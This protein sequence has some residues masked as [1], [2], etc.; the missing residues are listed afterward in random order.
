MIAIHYQGGGNFF[1]TR[2]KQ[3]CEDNNIPFKLVS[4]YDNDILEQLNDCDALL[5]HVNNLDYRDQLLARNLINAL[6]NRDIIT[7]PNNKTLWHFDDKVA[8][9]YLFESV[10]A[11]LV[12]SYVFYNKSDALNWIKKTTFPKV[13]KLAKGGAAVNVYLIK[14]KKHAARMVKRAFNKGFPVLSMKKIF[15]ERL[16]KFTKGQEPFIGVI[17]GFI[18]LFIATPFVNMSSNEKGYA[19]FQEF[20]PDNSFDIRVSIAGL[21]AMA[22]K[23]TVRENDFRASGSGMITWKKEEI[24]IN[25]VRI[26]FET[27]KLLGL[28]SAGYDFIYDEKG[29]LRI[30]EVSFVQDPCRKSYGDLAG[31]WD[32]EL[33]WHEEDNFYFEDWILESILKEIQS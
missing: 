12:K 33:N 26:A 21:K 32:S 20:L 28:Q 17:K 5:W 31:Y 1:C 18:R 25:C 27:S 19:Y 9:K 22:G 8:Q 10:D 29:E 15:L 23:R 11:P 7:Y 24:D 30:V 16:R 3:Y 14:N 4:C 6:E 13:F 2:W